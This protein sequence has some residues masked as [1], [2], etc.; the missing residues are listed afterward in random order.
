MMY[1]Y[2]LVLLIPLGGELMF[3][4]VPALTIDGQKLFQA[5]AICRYIA[6]KYEM[7]GKSLEESAMVDMLFE[8]YKDYIGIGF[9]SIEFKKTEEEKKQTKELVI[10]KSKDR[11]VPMFEKIYK[12]STSGFLVG[13][14]LTLADIAWLEVFLW[15]VELAPEFSSTFPSMAAFMSKISSV[16]RISAFLKGPQRHSP[17]DQEYVATVSKV[18]A[19]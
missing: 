18:L 1:L 7:M 8:A 9:L 5:G 12:K 14:S 6:R 3:N 19:F 16:P 13:D 2:G 11:Y 10:S 17:P 15:L 4:Q